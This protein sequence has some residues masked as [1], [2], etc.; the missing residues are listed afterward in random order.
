[1]IAIITPKFNVFY[2][3]SKED[4]FFTNSRWVY[5]FPNSCYGYRFD[6]YLLAFGAE[7]I[8]D[9]NDIIEYLE[10]HNVKRIYE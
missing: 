3:I 4:N 6:S 7:N 8:K 2:N 10:M 5:D 9:I 1:M